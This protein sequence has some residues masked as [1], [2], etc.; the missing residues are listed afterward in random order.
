MSA[1]PPSL[2]ALINVHRGTF[3][4]RQR[5]HLLSALKKISAT[6]SAHKIVLVS[7]RDEAALMQVAGELSDL[8]SP[9]FI[10][11]SGVDIRNREDIRRALRVAVAGFGGI[12]ILVNTAALFPSSPDGSISDAMWAAT[13]DINVTANYL[14]ADEV[15]RIFDEQGLDASIVFTSSANAVVPRRGREAYDVSNAALSH[16]IRELSV[17]LAP[18]VRVNGISLAMVVKGSSMF[19][20][21]RARASLTKHKI[22]FDESL[23]DEQ[24][25]SLLADFYATRTLTGQSVDPANCAEAILFL[26]GPKSH[27]TTGHLIPVDGGLTEGFLR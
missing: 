15:S 10:A 27:C 22:P 3:V 24:L 11:S 20:R 18:N 17:G 4:L 19:P 7:D 2:F 14:L 16:L 5:V 9:E 26:A 12:D 8:T 21:D 25:R 23:S 6:E 13:L 1:I